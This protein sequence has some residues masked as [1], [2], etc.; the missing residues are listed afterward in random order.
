MKDGEMSDQAIVSVCEKV[1]AEVERTS[2]P[3]LEQ[4]R[5]RIDGAI[6]DWLVANGMTKHEIYELDYSFIDDE[7]NAL[8][9]DDEEA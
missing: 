9:P 5:H 7:L 3:D 2:P 4:L 6:D 1:I 8:L